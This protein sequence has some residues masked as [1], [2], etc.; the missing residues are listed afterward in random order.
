MSRHQIS[1]SALVRMALND[2]LEKF[3]KTQKQ[4]NSLEEDS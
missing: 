2:L 4:R 3:E 1:Q